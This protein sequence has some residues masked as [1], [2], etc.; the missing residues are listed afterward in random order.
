MSAKER[1][2]TRFNRFGAAGL[3]VILAVFAVRHTESAANSSS[4]NSEADGSDNG[5]LQ[6][7]LTVEVLDKMYQ[8]TVDEAKSQSGEIND[9]AYEFLN[10]KDFEKLAEPLPPS[11]P[12][13]KFAD[14]SKLKTEENDPIEGK[15]QKIKPQLG[16]EVL[17]Q[18][19]QELPEILNGLRHNASIFNLSTDIEDLEMYYPIYRGAQDKTGVDW[20]VLW[21]MHQEESTVSRNPNAFGGYYEGC[22][23]RDPNYHPQEIVDKI[24]SDITF[25]AD[26]P[27]R[28]DTD[29][30]EIRWAAQKIKEDKDSTGSL[31]GAL[32]RYS[33]EGPAYRRFNRISQLEPIF[34]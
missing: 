21:V 33:A 19:K 29:W 11:T 3:V 31:L 8:L 28:H 15:L 5:R 18:Y 27:Q 16:A 2:L 34:E 10:S 17:N 12:R 6:V 14:V 1:D 26:L 22:M 4:D 7:G 32:L 23:Q 24:S 20:Y 9:N 30:K 25:L 13:Q